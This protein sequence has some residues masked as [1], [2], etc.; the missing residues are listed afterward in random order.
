VIGAGSGGLAAAKRAA[1]HGKK[2]AIADFVK[3]SPQGTTWGIGGTC[4]NVGCIPKKMMHFAASTGHLRADMQ[5]MG[6]DLN[7]Q[8]PHDWNKM[9]SNV[10]NYVK[11]LNWGYK[12]ALIKAGVKIFPSLASLKDAHTIHL[13]DGKGKEDTQTARHILVAVGGRPTYLDVPG[14]KE[15]CISSDDLFWMKK[16][17]GKTLVI[18]AGYIAMECGGFMNGMGHETALMVRST[19]LR[20]FDQDM[21]KKV[22]ED[23]TEHGVNFI[24]QSNPTKF[25][26][27]EEG[28]I[29]CTWIN[30]ETK[31]ECVDIFDTVLQAIGRYADTKQLGLDIAGVQHEHGKIVTDKD[32][33]TTCENIFAIGDVAKGNPELTPVAIREGIY[34][35]D[36]LYA[37][38]NK[39]LNYDHIPTTI[40][41]PLEYSC[42]GLSE[43][44]AMAKLGEENVE[45]YHTAFKPLEWNFL[46]THKDNRCYTKLIVDKTQDERIIGFHY[47]GPQAGEVLQGYAVA[48]T[49]G[50]TK[51]HF[52]DTLGIHPTTSEEIVGLN[53]KKSENPEA[54][55]EGC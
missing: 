15:Y 19:P 16:P 47:V 45:V 43:E 14:S 6:W 39:Y 52:D 12:K 32:N 25:E 1:A 18:G 37:G 7:L 42:M 33:K 29:K 24:M 38:G 44:K 40:F 28:R 49:A 11:S 46:K 4:V 53:V 34:L 8:Q 26:K 10:N 41:T 20:N 35:V 3:P 55:K 48:I 9:L 22:V 13:V 21:I 31:E 17:P 36:R 5:E 30:S 54:V 2:V 51:K 23:M 50:L 27:T